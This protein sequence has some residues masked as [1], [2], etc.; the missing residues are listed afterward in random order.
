MNKGK[1]V[2]RRVRNIDIIIMHT[3]NISF[4]IELLPH[5]SYIIC[6]CRTNYYLLLYMYILNSRY[7]NFVWYHF[8]T[9]NLKMTNKIIII[10]KYHIIIPLIHQLISNTVNIY[11]YLID[12]CMYSCCIL[13]HYNQFSTVCF[14]IID[15]AV[16]SVIRLLLLCSAMLLRKCIE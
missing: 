15:T 6:I 9:Y 16:S 12:K 5:T 8:M 7:K 3:T 2:K 13:D 1:Q 10:I 4:I 14:V 11:I